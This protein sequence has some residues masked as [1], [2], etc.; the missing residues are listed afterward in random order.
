[1]RMFD[2]LKKMVSDYSEKVAEY[3]Q[4]GPAD[5]ADVPPVGPGG[6]G[7]V[8]PAV[9]SAYLGLS[10]ESIGPLSKT[11]P[12]ATGFVSAKLQ[13]GL[14]AAGSDQLGPG[15]HFAGQAAARE[16]RLRA[17]GMSEE[18]IALVRQKIAEVTAEHQASGWTLTFANGT[19]ASVEFCEAGGEDS[20]FAR[21]QNAYRAQRVQA[22]M[23]AR[24]E[25]WL[26]DT[27][28]DVRGAPYESYFRGGICA[29]R[30]RSH[31]VVARSNSLHTNNMKEALAAL[32]AL[33]LRSLGD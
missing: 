3:S 4:S 13:E 21:L 11:G 2:R 26:L 25:S 16:A 1:M 14:R 9:A 31:E 7:A 30:G 15:E 12:E 32:A 18:Q 33:A 5:L 22:G 27:V 29:A 10:V 17:Q 19:H 8:D 23:E 24:Q 6:L 20:E 28:F